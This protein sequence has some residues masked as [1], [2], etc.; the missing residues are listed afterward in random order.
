MWKYSA[1]R[2][3]YKNE[4]AVFGFGINALTLQE[5]IKTAQKFLWRLPDSKRR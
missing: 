1:K 2:G 4:R 3:Q 5:V